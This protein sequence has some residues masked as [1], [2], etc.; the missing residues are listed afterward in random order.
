MRSAIIPKE[1]FGEAFYQV[2]TFPLK[3]FALAGGLGLLNCLSNMVTSNM[4]VDYAWLRY[5]I[6]VIVAIFWLI[7]AYLIVMMLTETSAHLLGGLRF[8]AIMIIC[9]GLPLGSLFLAL[10][11]LRAQSA[12]I[13]MMLVAAFA[14][15]WASHC[16]RHGLLLRLSRL[17]WCRQ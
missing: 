14:A 17:G 10:W 5:S 9:L 11:L 8:S 15:L 6:L 16:W 13:V 4:D 7:S 1:F 2:Q 3:S 12:G